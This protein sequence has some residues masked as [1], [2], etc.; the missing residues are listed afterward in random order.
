MKDIIHNLDRLAAQVA[1]NQIGTAKNWEGAGV[2]ICAAPPRPTK[3]S[4]YPDPRYVVT[5]HADHVS[6]MFELLRDI[7]WSHEGYGA[8][9]EEFF[10]RLGNVVQA[11]VTYD[12][13]ASAIHLATALLHEAYVMAEEIEDFGE[14]RSLMITW[15]RHILDDFLRLSEP[16]SMLSPSD[17]A[18]FLESLVS[19]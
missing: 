16:S 11:Q 6:W 9:K 12:P 14:L 1:S 17:S 19:E 5:S 2:V 10:G 13:Q 4:F 15:D 18:A 7:F 3:P 8:W